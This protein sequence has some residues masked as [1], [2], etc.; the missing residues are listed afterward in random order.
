MD[1]DEDRK[2]LDRFAKLMEEQTVEPSKKDVAI[3][4]NKYF[5]EQKLNKKIAVKNA[6]GDEPKKKRQ[7]SK[8][9]IFFQ[10]QIAILKEKEK[11]LDEEERMPARAMMTYVAALWQAKKEEDIADD[12]DE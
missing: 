1:I 2:F 7:P 5:T 3:A 11:E 6:L 12:D 8:Y 10:E 9:N 4:M